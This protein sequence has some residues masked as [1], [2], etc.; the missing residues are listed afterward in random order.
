MH[1]PVGGGGGRG[2]RREEH[3][4]SPV[5]EWKRTNLLF[6]ELWGSTY[7]YLQ[8]EVRFRTSVWCLVAQDDGS[9]DLFG[10]L[11][12]GGDRLPRIT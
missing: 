11:Q 9:A 2:E 7:G 6:P 1:E 10:K 4:T 12:A 3:E 5:G 8:L